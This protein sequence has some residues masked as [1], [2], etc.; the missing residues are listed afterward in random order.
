MID[1]SNI[2]TEMIIYAILAILLGMYGPNLEPKLPQ[3]IRDL[4]EC[5]LFRF[6]VI[7]LIIYLSNN[8]LQLAL[9]VSLGFMIGMSISNSQTHVEQF[10]SSC[11]ESFN[12]FKNI[13]EFYDESFE[14]SP[15]EDPVPDPVSE[16][17][18]GFNNANA[19]PSLET[20]YN[21]PH[22]DYRKDYKLYDNCKVFFYEYR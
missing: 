22:Y 11:D 16:T 12:D 4:F 3:N 7:L 8:H 6:S 17:E 9:I 14:N 18:E 5:K 21:K 1:I 13:A 15:Q 19:V 20:F 2:K 10:K